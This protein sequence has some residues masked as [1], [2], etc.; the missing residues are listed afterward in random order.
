MNEARNSDQFCAETV[1]SEKAR[2]ESLL[3]IAAEQWPHKSP[4]DQ[5]IERK[6]IERDYHELTGCRVTVKP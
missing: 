6:F 5:A 4:E 2:L 1:P 3:R